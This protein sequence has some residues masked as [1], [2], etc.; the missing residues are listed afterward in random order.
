MNLEPGRA[1]ELL[2]EYPP[3]RPSTKI[4][5]MDEHIGSIECLELQWGLAIPRLGER[6]TY[7]AYDVESSALDVLTQIVAVG[8]SSI[9]GIE[10]VELLRTDWWAKTGWLPETTRWYCRLGEERTEWLAVSSQDRSDLFTFEDQG[11]DWNW[12]LVGPQRLVDEGKYVVQPDG[13]LA[14]SDKPSQGAGAYRVTIG[15]ESFE[16]LR[17]LDLLNHPPS[18]ENELGEAFVAVN[19]RTVLYRQYRGRLMRYS[20][21]QDPLERTPDVRFPD[22]LRMEIDGCLYV[23]ANCTGMAHDVITGTALGIA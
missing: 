7:A 14:T 12:G 6:T 13:S 10:C 20:K 4:A 21:D 23:Q 19:G 15:N 22:N 8:P 16:C 18:E 3:K 5:P 11:F 17:V 1:T 2:K 9:H